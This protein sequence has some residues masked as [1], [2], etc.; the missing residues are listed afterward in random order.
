M[1]AVLTSTAE[2]SVS[3]EVRNTT[4]PIISNYKTSLTKNRY[5][6]PKVALNVPSLWMKWIVQYLN[7]TPGVRTLNHVGLCDRMFKFGVLQ[8]IREG[9]ITAWY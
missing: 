8:V 5:I 7:G 1:A 3:K 2:P 9:V 6:L 4:K